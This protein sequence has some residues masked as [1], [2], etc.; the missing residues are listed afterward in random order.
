MKRRK[1]KK[2]WL[3]IFIISLV[4]VLGFFYFY[5]FKPYYEVY[6]KGNLRLGFTEKERF[7]Y[8]KTASRFEE[9]YKDFIAQDLLKDSVSFR[10]TAARMNYTKKLKAGKY[11]LKMGMTNRELIKMLKEGRQVPVNI[12]LHKIRFKEELAGLFGNYLEPDSTDFINLLNDDTYLA[13]LGF[14]TENILSM[15]ISETYSFRWDVSAKG[16][17]KRMKTEHAKI[18]NQSRIAKANA[19]NFSI[20]EVMSLASIVQEETKQK[21]EASK[22][23]G[24]YI[25]RLKKDM[26]LQADPTLKYIRIKETGNKNIQ[27]IYNKYK[28]SESAYNTYKVKG[29]PP[30]PVIIPE[31]WAVDAVL[32]AERHDYL[33]FVAKDDFSGYSNFS[34]TYSEHAVHSQRYQEGLNERNIK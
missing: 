27:R 29:L 5:Y 31:L 3:I 12:S 14:N 13:S 21:A 11:L 30:G 18:W 4:S 1:G 16:A 24:V 8:I 25:N 28:D 9:V 17:L 7:F 19:L 22:I 26:L 20:P 10:V 32:N 2:K 34:K 15:F 23:A 33:F 6:N